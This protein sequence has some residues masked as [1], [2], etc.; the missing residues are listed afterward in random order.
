MNV[1]PGVEF[2]QD[3]KITILPDGS[4][5]MLASFPLPK[6]HWI[7]E[8]IPIEE[9]PVG[10]VDSR[11]RVDVRERLRWAIRGAT[12][13]GRDMDFDPDALVMLAVTAI[14]GPLK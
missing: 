12:G 14:C 11:H 13:N 3:K 7:F 4:G 5:V 8:D 1:P 6:D 10:F 2:P 9:R